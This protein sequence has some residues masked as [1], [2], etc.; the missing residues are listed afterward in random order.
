MRTAMCGSAALA[1]NQNRLLRALSLSYC[2]NADAVPYDELR[3]RL[4]KNGVLF[5]IE[6]I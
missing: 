5:A 2:N 1:R 4:E 3:T 6:G